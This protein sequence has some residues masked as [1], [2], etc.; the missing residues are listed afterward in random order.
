MFSGTVEVGTKTH[1][2][3]CPFFA[4]T[5]ILVLQATFLKVDKHI[6]IPG[7]IIY[8][9]DRRDG[10]GGSLLIAVNSSFPSTRMDISVGNGNNEIM[11]IQITLDLF[12]LNIINVY[13]RTGVITS[14]LDRVCRDLNGPSCNI[15]RFQLTS[16]GVGS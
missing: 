5:D 16:S 7:K 15:G 8:R 4:Q 1:F 9:L 3:Q 10:C 6:F 13:S 14:D 12:K 2:L 11:G